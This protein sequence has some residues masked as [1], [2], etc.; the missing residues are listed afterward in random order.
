MKQIA[1]QIVIDPN[2]RFGKPIIQDTRLTVEEVLDFLAGG[3][4]YEEIEKEYGLEKEK[5][6]AA[7]NYAASFLKGGKIQAV[8]A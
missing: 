3:M 8:K 6:Q 7:V 2:V 5:I 4:S 1:P